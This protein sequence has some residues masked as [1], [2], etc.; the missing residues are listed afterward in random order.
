MENNSSI[1]NYKFKSLLEDVLAFINK[2]PSETNVDI[3]GYDP[4]ILKL[5]CGI[6]SNS[7]SILFNMSLSN[8]EIPNWWNKARITPVYKGLK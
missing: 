7:L 5:S 4:C 6:I 1:Y 8:G 2:L 3:L